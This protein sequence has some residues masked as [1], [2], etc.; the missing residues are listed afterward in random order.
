[1]LPRASY[2]NYRQ[3]N[4]VEYINATIVIASRPRKRSRLSC[5]IWLCFVLIA[6]ATVCAQRRSGSTE[7]RGSVSKTVTVSLSPKASDA[8]AELNAFESG[9][10]VN[11][12]LSGSEFKRTIQVPILVRSNTAY[13]IT[14]SVQSQTAALTNV[15]VLSV[16]ATGRLVASDAV[17]GVTV[18]ERQFDQGPGGSFTIFSGPRISL[19]GGLDSPHNALKVTLLLSVQARVAEEGWLLNLKLQGSE[20]FIDQVLPAPLAPQD[21]PIQLRRGYSIASVCGPG[22]SHRSS[23]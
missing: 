15:Q 5:V 11:L 1:M 2:N 4:A 9:G 22:A 14:A 20:T 10:A 16:D 8:G 18:I 19:G 17:T 23:R 13:N 7:L 12:V 6:P 21:E 3:S